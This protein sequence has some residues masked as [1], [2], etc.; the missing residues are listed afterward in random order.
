[1]A[2]IKKQNKTGDNKRDENVEKREP[3]C[4]TEGSV[5]WCSHHGKQYGD[6]SRN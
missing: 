4:T 3:L 5:N 6:S 2:I 1:M